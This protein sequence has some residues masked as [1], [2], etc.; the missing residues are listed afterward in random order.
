MFSDAITELQKRFDRVIQIFSDTLPFEF[1]TKL[2][3]AA[4]QLE[5]ESVAYFCLESVIESQQRNY[6]FR[7]RFVEV[8]RVLSEISRDADARRVLIG[9]KA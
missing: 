4:R 8:I 6:F 7:M 9:S 5:V 3:R 1:R 2:V